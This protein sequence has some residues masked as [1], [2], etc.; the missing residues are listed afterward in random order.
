MDAYVVR[1]PL[2]TARPA[3]YIKTSHGLHL[4]ST[5][6]V[7]IWGLFIGAT[8]VIHELAHRVTWKPSRSAA[9]GDIPWIYRP[10]SGL[11]SILRIIFAQAHGPLTAMHLARLAV[12]ALDLPWASPN[13]WMEVFW[14]ADR[15]WA[16]PVGLGTVGWTLTRRWKG[17]AS[18]TFW[19]LALLSVVALATPLVLTRAY[20]VVTAEVVYDA[21]A[22]V[23]EV[24]SSDLK[25]WTM[26]VQLQEGNA[27]WRKGVSVNEVFS[28]NGF[29]EIGASSSSTSGSWL[30]TG[31][32]GQ[33]E[34]S[35]SGIRVSGQCDAMQT[36]N[37]GPSAFLERCTAEFGP[38][39]STA[40]NG[41]FKIACT[42]FKR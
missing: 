26:S 38:Q 30:F 17:G 32:P 35:L 41:E 40:I 24:K 22:S 39:L 2:S 15:R 3:G 36:T 10:G 12:N 31:D 34:V 27:L 29:A 11:P 16:G 13:T 18:I 6:A 4:L 1:S 7:V 20:P 25:E 33:V 21:V 8:I 42:C 9:G 19:S 5:C 14:L 28:R 37:K 23:I